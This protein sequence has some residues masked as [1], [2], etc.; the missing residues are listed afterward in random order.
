M[1][2]ATA[3]AGLVLPSSVLAAAGERQ[4][5]ANPVPGLVLLALLVVGVVLWRRRRRARA[6]RLAAGREV[7]D[8]PRGWRRLRTP[9]FTLAFLAPF[10]LEGFAGAMPPQVFFN[11]VVL[12]YVMAYYGSAAILIR[13]A[14]LAWRKG[15]PT[16]LA[17]GAAYGICE[18][19]LSTKVF[20][21]L[22][23]TNLGPQMQYGTW[24]G[25]H[26]PYTFHL[27]VVHAVFSIAIPIFLTTLLFPDRASTPW[28]RRRT[29]PVLGA[30]FVAGMLVAALA[31]FRFDPTPPHYLIAAG[32]VLVL[33]A[34]ARLLPATMALGPPIE[35][36]PKRLAVSG[37]WGMFAFFVVSYL[38]AAWH[39]P[40]FVT[41]I[42]EVAIVAVAGWLVS[43]V[44]GTE[45][46][47]FALV[48][49]ML[50]FFVFTSFILMAAGSVLQPLV[51]LAGGYGL[52]RLGRRIRERRATGEPAVPRAP[53]EST[54]R[55]E[56]TGPKREVDR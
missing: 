55:P 29:L 18:E 20:F 40:A 36:T 48:G 35:T 52:L 21:D 41:L 26:W 10:C 42:L 44:S 16:T 46:D 45:Y 15:W 8:G 2:L 49:G 7:P 53:A 23:R 47:H 9:A 56:R 54:T 28:V 11:P 30:V 31:L 32:V 4:E 51:S 39:V 14:T 13:E 3:P 1:A 5:D 50:G 38:F 12:V 34:V 37:F 24:A 22:E 33:V 17:L 6:A 27:I 19:G 25:V 43:R